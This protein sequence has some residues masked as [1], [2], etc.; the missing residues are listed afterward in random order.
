MPDTLTP[1]IRRRARFLADELTRHNYRYYVLDDPEIADSEYDRLMKEL[2]DLEQRWP[3]LVTPD[4]PTHRVGAPPLSKF[5]SVPHSLPMLSLDNAF[6]DDD[7]FEF[8]RRIR[9]ILKTTAPIP[10]MV[11]PKMDGVAVELIY[12][13]GLLAQA[14]TRGDGFVGEDITANVRTI[15]ALPLRLSVPADG[16]VPA[17]LE[18][19]GEIFIHR[20]A[21]RQFNRERIA[22]ELPPFA[23]PRNAAAGSLRQLDSQVTA[24]RPLN[25]F[26]YGIGVMQGDVPASQSELLARLKMFGLP[27][28]PLVQSCRMI[29]EVLAVYRELEARRETLPYDIDGMVIKVDARALQ[30]QLGT[31]ARSPRWAIAYKFKAIQA[32]TWL[33]A[34]EVQVGR[35]GALTPVAHLTPVS[36]GG[37]VVSRATLHNQDEIDRKDVRIGDTVLVQRAGDVIPEVVMPVVSKRRGD[38]RRFRM[39]DVCPSCGASVVRTEGEIA[40]R[41]FNA[42][43]PAQL[44]E[45]IRHFASKNAF[46]IDGLGEKLVD[47]L[48]SRGLVASFPDLFGLEAADLAGLDRMAERSAANL[49]AAL[50]AS[51]TI[52]FDRFIFALGIRHVGEHVARVLAKHF[53]GVAALQ[54]A[55][56]DALEAIEGIGPI[57]AASVASFFGREENTEMIRRLLDS[58]VQITMDQAEPDT[59]L[60]GLTF[61][62][63]GTLARMSRAQAQGLIEAAGGKV[64][65][66]VSRKT[67]YVVAGTSPG[68]KIDKARQL[69]VAVIDEARLW[70]MLGA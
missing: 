45:R 52:S 33:E 8:E 34:I 15:R 2:G 58:G 68:S 46:D 20:E 21:F 31:T 63:T 61:V 67:D 11:E 23:N 54:A 29:E 28:N 59:H 24:Q 47:Q 51:K 32:T 6:N 42:D 10:Y 50:Q 41:C 44:K 26:C 7:I 17:T 49:I 12:R 48:V 64:T 62:L 56:R 16:A 19:R 69:N 25:I 13:D 37:V 5:V 38:E 22:A 36:V 66:S 4:S 18:V 57:V 53:P 35:T 27:V 30:D 14:A 70:E 40:L 39:P 1:D 3:E 55:D 65:G 9:R 43:C 60:S